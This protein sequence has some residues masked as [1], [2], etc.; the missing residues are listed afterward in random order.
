MNLAGRYRSALLLRPLVPCPKE[1]FTP[2][3]FTFFH[4]ITRMAKVAVEMCP[5]IFFGKSVR[6]YAAYYLF[7]AFFYCFAACED[8]F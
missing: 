6:K 5:I 2:E 8:V 3:Y 1:H 7:G 4:L